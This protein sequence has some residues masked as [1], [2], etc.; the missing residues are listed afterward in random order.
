MDAMA[1]RRLR[2]GRAVPGGARGY[3]HG[4]GYGKRPGDTG[5]GGVFGYG[6]SP[7]MSL[8]RAQ[9]LASSDRLVGGGR[10]RGGDGLGP[11]RFSPVPLTARATFNL[12]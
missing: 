2:E 6:P 12:R 4:Y 3:G 7:T 11:F 10:A 9:P 8:G 1:A 5:R